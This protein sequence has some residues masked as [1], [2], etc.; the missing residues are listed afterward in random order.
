MATFRHIAPNIDSRTICIVDYENRVLAAVVSSY[1]NARG[2][3]LPLFTFPNVAVGHDEDNDFQE[4]GF[5]SRM[6]GAEFSV[7]VNNALARTGRI[8]HVVCVGLS[9]EQKSY[10]RFPAR[11]RI[12]DIDSMEEVESNLSKISRVPSKELRCK[13][14]DALSG[15][16]LARRTGCRL[17]IDESVEPIV[18]PVD[19]NAGV[20]V[21][22]NYDKAST[23]VG[24]NYALAI[25]ADLVVVDSLPESEFRRIPRYFLKWKQQ[26]DGASESDLRALADGRIAGMRFSGREYATFFTE[27]LPYGYFIGNEIPCS[28]VSL[29]LRPDLFVFNAIVFEKMAQFHSGVV[30]SPKFFQKEET[31]AIESLL[32]ESNYLVKSLVGEEATVHNLDFYAQHYAYDI[33]HICTHGGEVPGMRTT[34]DFTDRMGVKH[35]VVSDVVAAFEI[36]PGSELIGVQEKTFTRFFDGM[37]WMSKD[38]QGKRLPSYIF[39]DMRK[40][41]HYRDEPNPEAKHTPIGNVVDSCCIACAGNLFHQGTFRILSSHN[42]PYIFNNSCWSAGEASHFFLSSGA[43]GYIGTLW[44]IG[45]AEAV[46]GAEAFYSNIFKKPV[47]NAFADALLAI[48]NTSDANIYIFWGLHFSTLT[49]AS[50]VADSRHRVFR[51][52]I[53]GYRAWSRKAATSPNAEVKKN[54]LEIARLIRLHT[55]KDFR[56]EDVRRLTKP[57]IKEQVLEIFSKRSSETQ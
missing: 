27:G 43:R 45:V 21:V 15:L 9:V 14:A 19:P 2:G 49:T 22:E 11:I 44:A 53:R 40:A 31:E 18:L 46:D 13:S 20:I 54:S 26:G 29:R 57:T 47:L 50:S 4:D 41:F 25:G 8:E 56:P 39:E 52:L 33:F 32:K 51:E 55:T 34:E 23:I 7:L 30:F 37:E 10:L 5:L 42:S 28:H 3:Y 16:Y 1:F 17:V 38:M 24:V 36:I 35:T 48:S 6:V 12:I